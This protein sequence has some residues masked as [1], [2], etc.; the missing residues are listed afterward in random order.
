MNKKTVTSKTTQP[1]WSSLKPL[2]VG[3]LLLVLGIY[4]FFALSARNEIYYLCGNFKS[5]VSYSSVVR[6]LDTANLSDYKIEK[7]EQGKR[8]THSSALH[9]NLVRCEIIFA[10]DEKIRHAIYK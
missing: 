10:E 4:A 3:L 6:Q 7:S 8:V 2:L 1:G 5:G 9:L